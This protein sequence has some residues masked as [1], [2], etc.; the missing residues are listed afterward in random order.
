M[1]GW[2]PLASLHVPDPKCLAGKVFKVWSVHFTHGLW[3]SRR[4]FPFFM[5][6]LISPSTLSSSQ[7]WFSCLLQLIINKGE[8][9]HWLG[10][11]LYGKFSFR[12][13]CL[14]LP[15]GLELLKT[16]R[17]TTN[18]THTVEI[19]F[20]FPGDLAQIWLLLLWLEAEVS[21]HLSHLQ[22]LPDAAIW[23]L[24]ADAAEG[25]CQ[26][27]QGHPKTRYPKDFPTQNNR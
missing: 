9:E 14:S 26:P 27:E 7:S 18:S 11:K 4:R 8:Q 22:L 17:Q 20:S 1:D 16:R 19:P 2:H 25:P 12:H 5:Q 21:Q 6:Q 3:P 24:W 10:K 13:P 23:Q 15:C